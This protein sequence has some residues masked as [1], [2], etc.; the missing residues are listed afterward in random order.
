MIIQ[1]QIV[2]KKMNK[3]KLLQHKL[4]LMIIDYIK[5]IIMI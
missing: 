1:I 2:F 4:N 3:D 5:I